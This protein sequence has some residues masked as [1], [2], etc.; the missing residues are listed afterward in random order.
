MNDIHDT[1]GEEAYWTQRYHAGLTGWNIGYP[2]TPIAGYVDQLTDPQLRILI[3][4]AGN[5]FEAEYLF[6]KGF[7]QVFVLDI[8]APPLQGL[9]QR[10]PGF[11]AEH[12]IQENFFEHD[13]QYD[14]ILEQT[15][16]CSFPP[17]PTN[18]QEYA[19]Q[20]Y[21]LLK[22]GGKLVGLWFRHPLTGPD[23][24]RPFGGSLDEYLSYFTH[25]FEVRTFEPCY[26]S[27]P[28]RMGNEYFAIMEK[29][30]EAAL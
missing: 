6:Q 18:R 5:A 4:G 26:N 14:L 15:F 3:P 24:Q 20:M 1:Q 9:L 19:Q 13:G 29:A 11:P 17:T 21:R 30:R 12:L 8:A 7:S 16:F 22:P 10:V 28:P 25:W 27:I 23:D 2:A